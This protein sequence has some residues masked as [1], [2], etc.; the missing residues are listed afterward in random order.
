MKNLL[1]AFFGMA[2]ILNS[3][4]SNSS[5]SSINPK[6]GIIELPSKGEF[7]IWNDSSHASF[8][9]RLTNKSTNQSCEVYKVKNGNESWISPS[10]MAGETM[11]INVPT[12]GHLYFKNFN[13]NVLKINY[14][15][16]E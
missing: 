8:S 16:E 5:L 7:R 3:C 9:V 2:I 13:N 1:L 14:A 12:N 10:L 6:S 11:D 15:I 4:M